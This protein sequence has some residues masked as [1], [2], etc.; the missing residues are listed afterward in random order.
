MNP[1]TEAFAW[2][3][4]PEHW[5]GADGIVSQ[6]ITH[7]ELSTA[8]MLIAIAIAL[9]IGLWIGHTRR[10]AGVAVNAANIFRA[11]PSLA[12]IGLVL[13]FTQAFDPGLGFTLYPALIAM[14]VLATPP[15]LI[16]TYAG[17]SEVDADI[18]EAARGMG[19][20]DLQLL[21]RIEIPL[22]LP[23]ILG[24]IR[25][26]SVQVIA[27]VT[28]AAIYGAGGLGRFIVDGIAQND[29]GQLFGGV[30]LVALLATASEALFAL[31]QRLAQ[32]APREGPL[33]RPFREPG[34]LGRGGGEL[35][36]STVSAP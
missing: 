19:F 12:L 3:A 29:D 18:V 7:V 20:R 23:I 32:R 5:R 21:R 17:V 36:T 15:I 28:L 31:L 4:D 13:P 9:P 35:G 16:N 1:V 24:G 25:S 14:I 8:S 33:V 34:E 30:V 2:L 26:A 22:A 10:F 11:V 27:T 6:L